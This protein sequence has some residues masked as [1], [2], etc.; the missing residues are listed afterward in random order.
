MTAS[1]VAAH[2][3]VP[4][5][6]EGPKKKKCCRSIFFPPPYFVIVQAGSN[7][8]INS[9]PL[10]LTD[11]CII[12]GGGA[13]TISEYYLR[14]SVYIQDFKVIP[15]DHVFGLTHGRGLVSPRRAL[16]MSKEAGKQAGN[17]IKR[18]EKKKQSLKRIQ[19]AFM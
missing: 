8:L 19:A 14:C 15:G 13:V 18:K 17:P 12:N 16:L 11:R 6:K 1:S 2:P 7:P 5:R 4:Q 3:L 10:S 9:R